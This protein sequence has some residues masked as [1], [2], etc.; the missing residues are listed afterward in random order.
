MSFREFLRDVILCR[1]LTSGGSRISERGSPNPG[2]PTA[3]FGINFAEKCMKMEKM[4]WEG[5]RPP[6]IRQCLL[7]ERLWR[8][9]HNDHKLRPI[10][11]EQ[12]FW[13]SCISLRIHFVRMQLSPSSSFLN[14]SKQNLTMKSRCEAAQRLPDTSSVPLFMSACARPQEVF[15]FWQ[16]RIKLLPGSRARSFWRG[17]QTDRRC[18][19]PL[20]DTRRWRPLAQLIPDP[21]EPH[22]EK[23]TKKREKKQEGRRSSRNSP[24]FSRLQ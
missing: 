14:N 8:L 20:H 15:T 4:V 11:P 12:K 16:T 17:C 9:S 5:A 2:G 7:M 22:R 10:P 1:F 18:V 24:H 13:W 19:C 6:P 23:R 21:R 3:Q